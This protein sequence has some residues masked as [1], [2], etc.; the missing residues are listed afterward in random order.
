MKYVGKNNYR[1]CYVILSYNKD[2]LSNKRSDVK[3]KTILADSLDEAESLLSID[4]QGKIFELINCV[5]SQ[6]IKYND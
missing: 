1:F 2:N 3:Y 6:F 5:I 4:L